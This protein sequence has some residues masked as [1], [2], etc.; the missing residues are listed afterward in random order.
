MSA[1]AGRPAATTYY[2]ALTG[3]RMVAASLVFL[4]HHAYALPEGTPVLLRDL[5]LTSYVSVSMFFVLSGY[6]IAQQYF[7]NLLTFRAYWRFLALRLLRVFPIYWL[8]LYGLYVRWLFSVPELLLHLTLLKGYFVRYQLA[9]IVQSWT[10]TVE[11]TFYLLAPL[12]F[13]L[14]RSWSLVYT[15]VLC[16]GL[17]VLGATGAWVLSGTEASELSAVLHNMTWMTFFGRATEFFAGIGLFR[18]LSARQYQAPQQAS[19]LPYTYLGWLLLLAVCLVLAL[20]AGPG[21]PAVDSWPGLLVHHLLLPGCIAMILYG[22]MVE[23]TWLRRLLSLR[24][25]EVMGHATYIFYLIHIG[26]VRNWLVN[27]VTTSV[28]LLYLIFWL[29]SIA[30]HYL[31]ERPVYQWGKNLLRK[32]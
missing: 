14:I 11:L 3:F 17:G 29:L 23:Q 13:Y 10:L 5:V 1:V 25:V 24:V 8:L 18:L 30:G 12:L 9:G 31:V 28:I 27:Q 2:P 19:P 4:A 26:W 32:A 6:V 7:N 20:M 21:Q 15:W 16:L 22:L